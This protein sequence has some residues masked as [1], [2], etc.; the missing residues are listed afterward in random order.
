MVIPKIQ[1]STGHPFQNIK[2]FLSVMGPL[3]FT[4]ILDNGRGGR[5]TS[6]NGFTYNIQPHTFTNLWGNPI[7]E[8]ITLQI[9]ETNDKRTLFYSDISCTADNQLLD[10][11]WSIDI[12]LKKLSRVGVRQGLPI[13]LVLPSGKNKRMADFEIFQEQFAKVN[14]LE[15]EQRKEW[16]SAPVNLFSHRIGQHKEHF[17]YVSS[18]GTFLVGKKLRKGR[19]PKARAMLSVFL[20]DNAPKLEN[21]RAFLVFHES[22]T[23]VHLEAQRGR[24]SAFHLPKGRKASLILIGLEPHQFYLN[25]YFL[26][27]LNNTKI[28]MNLEPVSV[29]QLQAELQRM[30][31]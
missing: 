19:K 23:I 14:L 12:Q 28:E 24:F 2:D 31:F 17:F 22:D 29:H 16:T 5:F 27:P 7:E 21:V 13:R 18:P 26:G 8:E 4:I 15:G 6:P 20:K 30:I 11:E 10:V 9:F 3:P 25:R 1:T